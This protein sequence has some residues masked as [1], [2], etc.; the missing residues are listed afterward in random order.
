M[1]GL[2]S[3]EDLHHTGQQP[4]G[5][6]AHVCGLSGQPKA[7]DA[8]HRSNWRIQAA[9]SGAAVMGQVISMVVAPRRS[10]ILIT[11]GVCCVACTGSWRG[12]C[13]GR[14]AGVGVLVGAAPAGSRSVI[15]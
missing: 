5:A 13:T 11:G 2:G 6:S 15:W 7:V 14:N 12:S 8:D 4:I 10:S 9:Q 3:A 1:M